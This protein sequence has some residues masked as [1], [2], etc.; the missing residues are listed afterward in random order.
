MSLIPRHGID[1]GLGYERGSVVVESEGVPFQKVVVWSD[2]SNLF[3]RPGGIHG[4][5]CT[6]LFFVLFGCCVKS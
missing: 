3:L 1:H 2:I 5:G 4:C 6:P